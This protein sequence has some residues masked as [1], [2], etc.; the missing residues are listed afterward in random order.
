MTYKNYLDRSLKILNSINKCDLGLGLVDGPHVELLVLLDAFV[1]L[2]GLEALAHAAL[3][4]LA[5]LQGLAAVTA[6][7]LQKKITVND[8]SSL[9]FSVSFIP[10]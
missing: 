9:C 7:N 3:L 4:H 2:V 5:H 10:L 6:S 1:D 8:M